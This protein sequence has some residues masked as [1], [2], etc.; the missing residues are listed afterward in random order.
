MVF[1][2]HGCSKEPEPK[3]SLLADQLIVAV[4]AG[5]TTW[6]SGPHGDPAGFDHDLVAR[7][8]AERNLKLHTIEANS[9]TELL[10]KV[11]AGEAHMGVGGLYGPA[12]S[13]SGNIAADDARVLWTQG[14]FA[15]EPVVIY[16]VDGFKPKQ[17]QDLQ[18]AALTY[19]ESTGIDAQ[20]AA[21]RADH[22]EVTWTPLT[23]PSVDALIA[24][25]A[26]GAANYAIV[27]SIDA[28]AARNIHLDFDVAFVAGEKR[29]LAWAV[30]PSQTALRDDLDS[31]FARARRDGLLAR[32]ADRYFG[33]ARRVARID[34]GVFQERLNTVLPQYRALLQDAQAATGIEWRLLAAVAYQE[35]RWNPVATSETGVRG[36]MQITEE[37]ARHLGVA[38]RL[39]P[40]ISILA[41]A[42]YLRDLKT[43]LPERITEPDRT[44]LALAAFNIGVAHLEDARILTQKRKGNPDLWSDVRQAL[45]LLAVP[46]YH[47]QAKYGYA[48]GGMPVV[49]V[50]RVRAYYD[51][52][53]RH[54]PAFQP[55]LRAFPSEVSR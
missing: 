29:D 54:E 43:K 18:G 26:E 10:A 45:P 55:R 33:Y 42:R 41:G 25:V 15:V 40:K 14:H 12:A 38:D 7:F 44:W 39:D 19:T 34:A 8:A 16:N 32:L 36:I 50:D 24:L 52:L 13:G 23:V 37:T 9:A 20:F 2:L 21:I 17:W 28:A 11:A 53:L 5:P 27:P 6:F 22:P 35:S 49:F 48:R 1:M 4:H 46:E 30:A 31:F 51:I 3:T 47:E